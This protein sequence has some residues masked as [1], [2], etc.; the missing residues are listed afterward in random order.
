MTKEILKKAIEL[1]NEIKILVTILDSMDSYGNNEG[2]SIDEI[3]MP[4]GLCAEVRK[5]VCDYV[6]EKENQLSK[7]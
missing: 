4:S 5:V 2:C 3:E 7:L 6:I 1:D